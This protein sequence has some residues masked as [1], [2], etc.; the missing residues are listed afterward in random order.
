M[1]GLNLSSPDSC[2]SILVTVFH[3]NPAIVYTERYVNVRA[4]AKKQV[5]QEYENE[6]ALN[7]SQRAGVIFCELSVFAALA[8]RLHLS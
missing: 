8:P 1:L 3:S 2:H 4:A 5:E 6:K 7:L